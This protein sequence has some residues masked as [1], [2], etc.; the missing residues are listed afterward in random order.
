M[1]TRAVRSPA[2][3]TRALAACTLAAS[4]LLAAATIPAGPASAAAPALASTTVD[5][6]L[7]AGAGLDQPILAVMPGGTEVVLTG[8]TAAGF[9]GVV[10][11]GITGWAAA[12][13]LD[14]GHGPGIP[15]GTAMVDNSLRVAP[16]PDG[17][18]LI[19]VPAGRA[20]MLTGAS[21]EGYLAA[22]FG[23]V[24]GWIAAAD[25]Q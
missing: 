10:W 6:N 7:R 15:L 13:Y 2:P 19:V 20:V 4:V 23:G 16:F 17:E 9:V 21:I 5:L 24:G 22:A 12:P 11:A 3:W 25:L 18:V 1:M 14:A 8:D